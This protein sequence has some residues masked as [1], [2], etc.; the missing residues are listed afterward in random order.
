VTSKILDQ[1]QSQKMAAPGG[2][3][4]GLPSANKKARTGKKPP[5]VALLS[6]GE[7]VEEAEQASSGFGSIGQSTSQ[8]FQQEQRSRRRAE[9]DAAAAARTAP[10][11]AGIPVHQLAAPTPAA[12]SRQCVVDDDHTAWL[13]LKL[14]HQVSERQGKRPYM[15]DMSMY[16]PDWHRKGW[17]L[18]G[19]FD[20]E[21]AEQQV[22]PSR[23]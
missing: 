16:E 14:R 15:E 5:A 9:E 18:F 1:I 20:G 2:S 6:F 3:G 4:A 8:R 7:E 19:V 22:A 23:L 11:D 13:P 12:A 17:Y 10:T 21:W